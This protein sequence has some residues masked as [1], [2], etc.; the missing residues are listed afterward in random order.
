MMKQPMSGDLLK[1][2]KKR[3]FFIGFLAMEWVGIIGQDLRV[4]IITDV[5]IQL[6][7]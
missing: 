1:V 2:L 4:R 5:E 7:L 3:L 6:L